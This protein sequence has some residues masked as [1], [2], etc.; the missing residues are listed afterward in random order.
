MKYYTSEN[1]REFVSRGKLWKLYM[2]GHCHLEIFRLPQAIKNSRQFLLLRT[3]ISEKTVV[4]CP[5]MDTS[6][7]FQNDAPN[8]K[9]E[10]FIIVE[11]CCGTAWLWKCGNWHPFVFLRKIL[12]NLNLEICN[13]FTR[14]PCKAL[15]FIVTILVPERNTMYK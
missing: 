3:D 14:P 9:K 11:M 13:I 15:L 4:G 8:F 5:W 1:R 10:A 7:L 6:S 12:K 2:N